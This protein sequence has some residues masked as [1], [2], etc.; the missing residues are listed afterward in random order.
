MPD[1]VLELAGNGEL[2]GAIRKVR[3]IRVGHADSANGVQYGSLDVTSA[4]FYAAQLIDTIEFMHGR[5]VIHRDLK[6][7]KCVGLLVH[8]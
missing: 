5:G 6:P 8:C 2:L 7:E 4:R 1:F 3:M